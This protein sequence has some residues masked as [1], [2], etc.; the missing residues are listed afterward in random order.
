[1][2]ALNGL[3][4]IKIVIR[5]L[6]PSNVIVESDSNLNVKIMDVGFQSLYAQKKPIQVN[7][8]DKKWMAPDR[9]ITAKSDIWSVGTITFWLLTKE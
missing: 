1:M 7:D 8:E 2:S 3:N 5:N 9:K 4:L 6:K